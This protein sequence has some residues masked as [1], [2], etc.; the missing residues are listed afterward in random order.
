MTRALIMGPPG[1]GKG[2][3]AERVAENFNMTHLSSG[4]IFRA[5]KESDSPLGRQVSEV[6]ARGE[7]VSDELVVQVMLKAISEVDGGL[8]L[9]G[10]P[11]TLPQ[12]E[13]LDKALG[14][15]GIG[16]DAVILIKAND[17]IIVERITGRR[18]CPRCGKGFHVKFMPSARDEYC[19]ECDGNVKLVQR[20]DDTE[21]VVRQRLKAYYDQTEPVVEYYRQSD[22]VKVLEIDGMRTPD[23]V[24]LSISKSLSEFIK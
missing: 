5:E 13:S 17:N 9:D 20:D 16:I 15:H 10:F 6:M 3:Q 18:Y 21:S 22:N 4:D 24:S 7:L 1:A 11:R 19:D 14:D 12:A 23:E 8:L 2:T